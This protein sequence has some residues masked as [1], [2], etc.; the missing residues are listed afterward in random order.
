M[1]RDKFP[2]KRYKE[3]VKGY[4][5]ELQ[6]CT[7]VDIL[8]YCYNQLKQVSRQQEGQMILTASFITENKKQPLITAM[9]LA[10]SVLGRTLHDE[11]IF[12]V[13]LVIP[14]TD[15]PCLRCLALSGVR[16]AGVMYNYYTK[17]SPLRFLRYLGIGEKKI[18]QLLGNNWRTASYHLA[19]GM[20]ILGTPDS[21]N[22][23]PVPRISSLTKSTQF[24]AKNIKELQ[25][26]IQNPS[27]PLSTEEVLYEFFR[28]SR[29]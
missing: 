9:R 18:L 13:M 25:E 2:L 8:N 3:L 15:T 14:D 28:I 5:Q 20:F 24:S 12:R 10:S 26:N 23:G 11:Q 19:R 22:T 1:T 17:M 27:R 29:D 6:R 21:G 16:S 7:P 4:Y